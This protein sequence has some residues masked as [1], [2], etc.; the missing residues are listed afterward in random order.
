MKKFQ[1]STECQATFD[2]L[3]QY[4]GT[5]PL[6]S[7]PEPDNV[8]YLCLAVFPLAISLVLVQQ[9]KALQKPVYYVN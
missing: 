7:K 9:E 8:Q 2:E 6:L 5:L 4:L 3:K 1:W